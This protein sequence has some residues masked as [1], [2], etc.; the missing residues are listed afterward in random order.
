MMK[1]DFNLIK[2]SR[3]IWNPNGPFLSSDF[4][5]RIRA[6]FLS[7]KEET[8]WDISSQGEGILKK[9]LPWCPT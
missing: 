6:Q 7:S 9:S 5:R 1:L 2:S 4:S 3:G 8:K